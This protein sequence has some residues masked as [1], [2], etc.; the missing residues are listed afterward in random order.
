MIQRDEHNIICQFQQDSD[1]STRLDGGDSLNRTSMMAISGSE[2]DLKL[3]PLFITSDGLLCR[4]PFQTQWAGSHLSSRDQV[5]CALMTGKFPEQAKHYVETG[6][7]NGDFLDW[8][9]RWAI[10]EVYGFE[11]PFWVMR[12]GPTNLKLSM[13]WN[14]KIDPDHEQN[15]FV[16]ICIALGK[17]YCRELIER[18]P[19]IEKNI[20][21]YFS[22]WRNQPEIGHLFVKKLKETAKS[23]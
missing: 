10:C 14:T 3:L 17:E 19:D 15:Q 11:K 21:E 6:W 9:V 2:E 8:G 18:H 5:V 12:L 4:H 22:G 23:A 7:V 20:M 1:G 13:F 16:C